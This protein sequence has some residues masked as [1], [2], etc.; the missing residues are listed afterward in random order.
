ME[1]ISTIQVVFTWLGIPSTYSSR[2]LSYEV[3]YAKYRGILIIE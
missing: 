2:E 1:D 3:T